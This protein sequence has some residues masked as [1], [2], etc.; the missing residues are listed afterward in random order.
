MGTA[1][2]QKA[3]VTGLETVTTYGSSVIV[4]L[5]G[6]VKNFTAYIDHSCLGRN[7]KNPEN[8]INSVKWFLVRE[9]VWTQFRE[10]HSELS[11][12]C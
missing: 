12:V 8:T 10:L 1:G 11:R 9:H 7:T 6:E 2:I 4:E 3:L 5:K